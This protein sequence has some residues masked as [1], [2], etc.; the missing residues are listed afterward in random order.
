MSSTGKKISLFRK[1]KG[2]GQKE[3]A[4]KLNISKTAYSNL[5]TG[6]ADISLT[7]LTEIALLLDITYS[8]LLP[9]SPKEYVPPRAI[10][11]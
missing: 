6:E 10:K 4:A 1:M 8:D 11:F 5:E 7:R 9:T 3:L 2:L